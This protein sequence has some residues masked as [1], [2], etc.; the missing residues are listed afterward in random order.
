MMDA[1]N[2]MTIESRTSARQPKPRTSLDCGKAQVFADASLA[3]LST[4]S[5]DIVGLLKPGIMAD[6]SV[7]D[8]GKTKQNV[9]EPPAAQVDAQPRSRM[10]GTFQTPTRSF[11]QMTQEPPEDH[12]GTSES[13]FSSIATTCPNVQRSCPRAQTTSMEE[14]RAFLAELNKCSKSPPASVY[15]LS[16]HSIAAIKHAAEKVGFH[17]CVVKPPAHG[18]ESDVTDGWLVLGWDLH[19]VKVLKEELEWKNQCYPPAKLKQWGTTLT[20]AACGTVIGAVATFTGLA[21]S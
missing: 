11:F 20:V 4:A 1:L 21:F 3:S 6:T 16:N 14:R 9:A 2:T 18:A 19:A 13:P 15:V 17:A 8:L 10:P 5:S 7:N 12:N